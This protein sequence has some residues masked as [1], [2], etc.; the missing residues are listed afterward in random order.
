MGTRTKGLPDT[1]TSI[2]KALGG[3]SRV[4]ILEML[5]ASPEGLDAR[6][7]ADRVGLH[8]NTVRV[9]LDHLARAGLVT[10]EAE[11]RSEPG[12]PRILYRATAEASE[13][14]SGY[15]LLA[16]VLAGHLAGSSADPAAEAEG[17]GRAW[18]AYLT[19]PPAP[20]EQLTVDEALSRVA[21]ML[22][23]LGFRPETAEGDGGWEI[24]LH[25]CPFQDVAERHP[26][27]VCAVHLGLMRGALTE[28]G[29]PLE[30]RAL[31]PFVEPSL[32]VAHLASADGGSRPRAS[33][34]RPST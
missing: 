19:R 22:A 30:A 17:A 18:G 25:R 21:R 4:R 11:P 10:G 16:E 27:V 8:V 7:V 2:H 3:V 32:C 23:D 24:L 34:P 15:R 14:S 26:D 9:H 31:D 13:G 20:F 28:L 1:E 12:R 29:A 5:R 33:S 6:E